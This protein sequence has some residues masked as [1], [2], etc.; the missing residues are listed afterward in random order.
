MMRYYVQFG[1]SDDL[2]GCCPQEGFSTLEE[3]LEAL[4]TEIEHWEKYPNMTHMSDRRRYRIVRR[5]DE[6][7]WAGSKEVND[8]RG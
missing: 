7:V 1:E 4:E 6:I 8:V 2:F 5:S 3:A